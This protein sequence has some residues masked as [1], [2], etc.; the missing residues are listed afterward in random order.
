MKYYSAKL[1]L[2]KEDL[3]DAGM[4][5][6]KVAALSADSMQRIVDAVMESMEEMQF[7]DSLKAVIE[8]EG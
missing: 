5:E 3:I 2:C 1:A 4:D 7:Q 8:R 6:K